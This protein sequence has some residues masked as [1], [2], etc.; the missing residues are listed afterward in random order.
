MNI[1][2]IQE[3]AKSEPAFRLGQIR[4]AVFHDLT[5]KWGEATALP[6]SL[7]EKLDREAPLEISAQIFPSKDGRTLKAGIWLEDGLL[8]ETVLMKHTDKRN[9]ICVSSQV[10][11]PLGC[12][13]CET[14][15]MGFKKNLTASEIVE[16]VL[17]FARLLKEKNEK[18]TNIVFMGMGEP[19]LNWENVKEAIKIINDDNCFGIGARKISIST[20]G[21]FEGIEALAQEFPQINLAISQHAPDDKLRGEL[22]PV[23][24]K[25]PLEKVLRSVD[26]YIKK[27]NRKVMF[28]YV[29]IDGV[30]D[31]DEQAEK[32][33]KLLKRPLYMINLIAY[34]PTGRFKAS[35]PARIKKFKAILEKAGI[36]TT[37]RYRFGTDIEAACGQLAGKR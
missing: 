25:Y 18:I 17:Y 37:Q 10:G 34:N 23:N 31:S 1:E 8:V 26:E 13:F 24:K 2:K 14:G 5:S 21:I 19:F 6:K 32:L 33:S 15:K 11:C 28:E 4:K 20:A 35:P 27:T 9:T 12:L 30:N 3:I 7:R 29:M 16:Q 22:M 36:F